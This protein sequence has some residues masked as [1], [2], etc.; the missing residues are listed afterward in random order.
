MSTTEETKKMLD[1]GKNLKEIV[2]ERGLKFETILDHI[3]KINDF[4]EKLIYLTEEIFEYKQA[5]IISKNSKL[6]DYDYHNH[7]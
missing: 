1:D 5:E 2:K 4:N 7:H 6:M 3:E